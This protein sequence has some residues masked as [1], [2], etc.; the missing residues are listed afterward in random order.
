[1]NELLQYL[2]NFGLG[3]VFAGIMFYIYRNTRE[4]MR[5]DRAFMEERLTGIINDY[6]DTARERNEVMLYNNQLLF[7]LITWL[8]AKNGHNNPKRK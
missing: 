4:Q 5:K 1:M 6:R 8:K 3:A 2:L 7:E